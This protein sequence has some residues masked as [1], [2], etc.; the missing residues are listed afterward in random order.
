MPISSTQANAGIGLINTGLQLYNSNQNLS[1]QNR[2]D[3]NNYNEF[4]NVYQSNLKKLSTDF[5][6][7]QQELGLSAMGLMGQQQVMNGASGVTDLGMKQ[8]KTR[9]ARLNLLQT[10]ADNKRALEQQKRAE[11]ISLN[12]RRKARQAQQRANTTSAIVSALAT[13]AMVALL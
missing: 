12:S 1:A 11:Q 7:S 6:S 5:N 8:D 4:L 13:V 10:E 2:A 3:T 9:Q